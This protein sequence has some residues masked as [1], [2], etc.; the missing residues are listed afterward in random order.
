VSLVLVAAVVLAQADAGIADFAARVRDPKQRGAAACAA[1]RAAEP[2][3]APCAVKDV[4]ESPGAGGR[5]AFLVFFEDIGTPSLR[6]GH[7]EVFDESGARLG[8]FEDAN[9][10]EE[11]DAL[12]ER[13]NRPLLVVEEVDDGAG[14]GA[15]VQ[16]VHVISLEAPGEP[17]L[18]LVVGP[19]AKPLAVPR[20]NDDSGAAPDVTDDLA[21]AYAWSWKAACSATTCTVSIGPTANMLRNKA[22]AVFRLNAKTQRFEGPAGSVKQGFLRYDAAKQPTAVSD[23]AAALG[24]ACKAD[25]GCG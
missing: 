3:D 21:P 19:P 12:L 17:V 2:S 7:F 10:L 1:Q 13:P 23:F 15:Q 5:A 6:T 4:V 16:T 22:A 20:A 14:G 25:G 8:W 9:V 11:H 24:F 18:S